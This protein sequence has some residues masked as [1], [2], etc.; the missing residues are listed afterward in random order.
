MRTNC[1]ITIYNKY[2]VAGTETYQ[3]TQITGVEWDNHK[4]ANIIKSGLVT[5][6]QASIYIPWARCRA[7]FSPKSWLSLGSKTGKWT[8][9]PGDYIVKGLVSDEITAG[10]TMTNLKAKYDDVLQIKSIDVRDM[11]SLGM[12]HIQIGAS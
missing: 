1:N 9:A 4:G 5:A 8:V 11:G 7:Y 12:W 2:I 3:R 6:D 10:F